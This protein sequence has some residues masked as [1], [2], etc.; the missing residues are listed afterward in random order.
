MEPD[1]SIAMDRELIDRLGGPAKVAELLGFD[2]KGGVQRVH[3]WK[4]RGI[5]SAVKV[6]YPDIFLN[7]PKSEEPTVP[8]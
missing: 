8:A 1:A 2:K 7:P 6:A 4:E 5:P 3:N